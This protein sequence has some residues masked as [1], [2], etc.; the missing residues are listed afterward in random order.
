M[1]RIPFPIKKIITIKSLYSAFDVIYDKDY[2][3][4]GEQHDFW[5]LVF[6]VDGTLGVAEDERVYE[7]TKNQII[8]HKPFAF[9]RLWNA[10]NTPLSLIIMSFEALG[11]SSN[12]LSNG[13]FNLSPMDYH[14]LINTLDEAKACSFFP[15]D[16]AD[17]C[18]SYTYSEEDSISI[19]CIAAHLELLFLHLL[20]QSTSN[21][22][23]NK[24]ISAKNYKKIVRTMSEHISENL[25]VT[26][27]AGLC[28][29]S[30]SNM[31]KTFSMYSGIGIM[32][33]FNKMK[34]T[35]AISLFKEGMSIVEVSNKLGFSNQNYFSTVFK[36]EMGVSPM[37]YIK[38]M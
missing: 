37:M 34:I 15:I 8:F 24:S 16:S 21:T 19:Q 22:A 20:R 32:S 33:Y 23:Q 10:G 4:P 1:N 14:L 12:Q 7:L 18:G 29:L 28:D 2:A 3:F 13:V 36:R 35:K 31:K 38:M 30:I 26:D 27:I 5:E 9:H 17:P 11:K 6:V 25:S